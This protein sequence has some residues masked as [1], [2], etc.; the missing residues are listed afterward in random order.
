MDKED[1]DCLER[2]R[3]TSKGGIAVVVSQSV[4]AITVKRTGKV[5]AGSRN[6]VGR[7]TMRSGVVAA[8]GAPIT[9]AEGKYEARRV[10]RQQHHAQPLRTVGVSPQVLEGAAL[11][12]SRLSAAAEPKV[13]RGDA[14][15]TRAAAA[16]PPRAER[17]APQQPPVPQGGGT[18]HN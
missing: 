16:A 10:E 8:R 5:G 7:S 1:S 15:V 2:R 17:A 14:L 6:G 13:M 9:H 4:M 12:A 11:V 18:R 3:K